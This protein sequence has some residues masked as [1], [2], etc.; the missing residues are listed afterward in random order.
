M[1]HLEEKY[2]LSLCY[3]PPHIEL[4][5]RPCGS[6]DLIIRPLINRIFL[7][8]KSSKNIP[9]VIPELYEDLRHV[10]G[11]SGNCEN[12]SKTGKQKQILNFFP[13]FLNYPVVT[14]CLKAGP[15][16]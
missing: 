11:N 16:Q 3:R 5:L 7:T 1:M 13:V 4:I 12:L 15:T 9:V 6:P 14:K 10:T 8:L 2:Y